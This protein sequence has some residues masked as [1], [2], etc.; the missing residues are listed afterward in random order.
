[1]TPLI[2]MSGVAFGTTFIS[3]HSHSHCTKLLESR[4]AVIRII[5]QSLHL[6][7]TLHVCCLI[8]TVLGCAA[9]ESRNLQFWIKPAAINAQHK[10][11]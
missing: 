10:Q 2:T 9:P 8:C 5:G 7:A 3:E 1:M 11:G 4:K 6:N